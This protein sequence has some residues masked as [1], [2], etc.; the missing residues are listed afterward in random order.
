MQNNEEVMNFALKAILKVKD[1]EIQ[2]LEQ[3]KEELLSI[4][5]ELLSKLEKKRRGNGANWTQIGGAIAERSPTTSCGDAMRY[6][7]FIYMY[8]YK[9]DS[10]GTFENSLSQRNSL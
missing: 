2:S 5:E 4:A 7:D 1:E 10:M 3:E 6:D 8:G 9:I